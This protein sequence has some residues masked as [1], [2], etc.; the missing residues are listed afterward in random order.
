MLGQLNFRQVISLELLADSNS[1]FNIW[2][3]HYFQLLNVNDVNYVMQTEVH[4]FKPLVPKPPA[5]EVERTVENF[6]RY[7][8][9]DITQLPTELV[10]ACD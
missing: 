2:K 10:Q 6:K 8:S 5:V 1:I 4:T 9:P 7:E 3:N